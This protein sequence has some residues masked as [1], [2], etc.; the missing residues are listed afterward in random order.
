VK[1][2]LNEADTYPIYVFP[3]SESCRAA[4]SAAAGH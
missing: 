4:L 1:L 3:A 2:A